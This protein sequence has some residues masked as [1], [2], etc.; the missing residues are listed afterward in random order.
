MKLWVLRHAKSDWTRALP[1]FDRDLNE[2]GERNAEEL[3]TWLAEQDSLPEQIITSP[4]VRAARTAQAARD[5]CEAVEFTSDL[6][7]YH[8]DAYSMLRV[9]NE[10]ADDVDSLLIAGHNPGI[11]YFVNRLGEE[12]VIDVLPTCGLA[13]FSVSSPWRD[14]DFGDAKLDFLRTPKGGVL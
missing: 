6:R 8:G 5:A 7:I 4:A 2:R 9:I 10:V 11:T 3:R 14:L 12:P 13:R 1:D